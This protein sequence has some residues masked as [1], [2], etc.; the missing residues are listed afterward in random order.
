MR[1]RYDTVLERFYAALTLCDSLGLRSKID[2]GRFGIYRERLG[3]WI[4]ALMEHGSANLPAEFRDDVEAHLEQYRAALVEALEFGELVD[5]LK[6]CDPKQVR[7]KLAHVLGGPELP[8]DEDAA[9][10]QARNIQFE[11][12]FGSGLWKAGLAPALGPG[13][14]I[15]LQVDDQP[16]HVECKRVFSEAKLRERIWAAEGQLRESATTGK[17]D[18]APKGIVAVS[19]AKVLNPHDDV[20]SRPDR[21]TARAALRLALEAASAS[22]RED[23]E[24]CF[25]AGQVVGILFHGVSTFEN[26]A[27]GVLER[28]QDWVGEIY[29]P[30]SAP[31]VRALRTIVA[32][33]EALAR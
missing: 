9:S 26:F 19:L 8:S 13:A 21:L 11:L 30:P 23:W 32:K 16:F 25:A 4:P 5:Y 10:N 18:P 33:T 6:S 17:D 14:D 29:T 15:Y 20:I 3:R 22:L 12:F 2:G 24:R 28:G 1:V 7:M 31:Y 27:E